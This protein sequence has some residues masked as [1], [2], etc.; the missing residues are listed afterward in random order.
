[1]SAKSRTRRVDLV[2]AHPTP[3]RRGRE[4]GD[5]RRPV[6]V[7]PRAGAP[8]ARSLV[9]RASATR[10]HANRAVGVPSKAWWFFACASAPASP[11]APTP[12]SPE[13][14]SR[15]GHGRRPRGTSTHSWAAQGPQHRL[16][17]HHK[18]RQGVLH[19]H[20]HTDLPQMRPYRHNI[21]LTSPIPAGPRP[22]LGGSPTTPSPR[23]RAGS[24]VC[25][26]R[27]HRSAE[28]YPHLSKT[29]PTV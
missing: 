17:A 23:F 4:P 11:A 16:D 19:H 26:A 18:A 6:P 9:M 3:A 20:Q 22:L 15:G 8:R 2:P 10:A 1:M 7:R 13:F 25:K 28:V 14:C 27:S 5:L 24:T 12:P 29:P 21:P